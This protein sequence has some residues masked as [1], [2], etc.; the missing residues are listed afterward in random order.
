MVAV[1]NPMRK[2]FALALLSVMIAGGAVA[3][4]TVERPTSAHADGGGCNGC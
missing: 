3:L 2:L 1:N 4:Y